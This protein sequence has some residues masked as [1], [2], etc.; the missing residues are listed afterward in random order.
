MY[1]AQLM[2]ERLAIAVLLTLEKETEP[3]VK[4]VLTGKIARSAG[5]VIDRIN[6]L[7]EAGL[8]TE[9]Q[10]DKRPFRKFVELTPLGRQVAEH[11]AA[12]EEILEKE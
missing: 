4:G 1:N 7:M 8:V 5:T 12:I 11:L 10:E 6:E 3:I 9:V 2:E